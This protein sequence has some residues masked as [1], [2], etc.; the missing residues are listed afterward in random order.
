MSDLPSQTTVAA[1][2]RLM[3]AAR[4]LLSAVE[5]DL[6]SAGLPP[7]GWYDVLLELEREKAGLRPFELENRLLL[8]QYNLSRLVDRLRDA[9]YVEKRPSREDRRGHLLF[10]T[11]A[12]KALRKRIWPVYA[13][14]IQRHVGARLSEP[15]AA[16]LARILDLL[17]AAP[18]HPPPGA[19]IGDGD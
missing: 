12:G 1:W 10:I 9:G 17:V 3:K 2:A 19:E 13:A 14:C 16:E 6:K 18:C 5:T 7:L 11:P 4:M 8:E 15:E